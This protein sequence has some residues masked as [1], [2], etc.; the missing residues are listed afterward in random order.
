MSNFTPRRDT[1]PRLPPIIQPI[2]LYEQLNIPPD[3]QSS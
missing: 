1:T 2:T 3:S